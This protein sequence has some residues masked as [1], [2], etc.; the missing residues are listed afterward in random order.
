MYKFISCSTSGIKNP[1]KRNNLHRD[2]IESLTKVIY[3]HTKNQ[4][5]MSSRGSGHNFERKKEFHFQC[6]VLKVK[7][8]KKQQILYMQMQCTM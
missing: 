6:L 8:E 5:K 7:R 1:S 2:A 3:L 4:L